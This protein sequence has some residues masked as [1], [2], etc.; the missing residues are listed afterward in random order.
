MPSPLQV[1]AVAAPPTDSEEGL[2]PSMEDED[3]DALIGVS[4]DRCS[5]TTCCLAS[6]I[7]GGLLGALALLVLLLVG[8]V[9]AALASPA[10]CQFSA[11][12]DS[13]GSEYCARTVYLVLLTVALTLPLSCSCCL[14]TRHLR[15]APRTRLRR[16]TTV[17]ALM[18]KRLQV[19]YKRPGRA[20]GLVGPVALGD[21][22][23]LVAC[24]ETGIAQSRVWAVP[25]RPAA[26]VPTQAAEE[27]A[28]LDVSVDID[29]S[30]VEHQPLPATPVT[31]AG[32][33]QIDRLGGM[34]T[35]CV[36]EVVQAASLPPRQKPPPHTASLTPEQE[37]AASV[38]GEL[39]LRRLFPTTVLS[40]PVVLQVY[41]WNGD[42]PS[43]E[44]V[45]TVNSW[46]GH[47]IGIYHSGIA[48]GLDEWG[49]GF[50]FDE[51]TGVYEVPIGQVAEHRLRAKIPLGVVE[52]SEVELSVIQVR[53]LVCTP[54]RGSRALT[55]RSR[56]LGVFTLVAQAEFKQ[57]W[58]GRSYQILY[59]NCNH[60]CDA[61]AKRLNK[62]GS[63]KRVPAW[64]N[65]LAVLIGAMLVVASLTQSCVDGI[66]K[67]CSWR[68][69]SYLGSPPTT[70]TAA[71]ANGPGEAGSAES[72]PSQQPPQQRMRTRA[73]ADA[74]TFLRTPIKRPALGDDER[75]LHAL[76]HSELLRRA[77]EIGVSQKECDEALDSSSPKRRIV[78]LIISAKENAAAGTAG[79]AGNESLNESLEVSV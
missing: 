4:L 13:L 50:T 7:V 41:D 69:Y 6:Q 8:A 16:E 22:A 48:L 43:Y 49:Y 59:Q 32:M 58:R 64:V 10:H 30:A 75:E 18:D 14:C 39:L 2:D 17:A 65:R 27:S 51:R 1:G 68:R 28:L 71:G 44:W 77:R 78:A 36:S 15:C 29:D 26:S 63:V 62:V 76:K 11:G 70:T 46:L 40:R 57:E 3:A 67:C 33:D 12:S 5:C 73:D 35:V 20:A 9:G 34:A 31:P 53:V 23:R 55:T 38:V 19:F 54:V 56:I 45:I 52:I 47:F 42:H 25:D 61:V 24:R 21:L 60:F 79:A 72:Q 66:L 37:K 74:G